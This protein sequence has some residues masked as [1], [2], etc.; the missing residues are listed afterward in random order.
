MEGRLRIILLES[1]LELVPRELQE[2]PEVIK[3]AKRYGISPSEVILDKSLHYNAMYKLSRKWK[4]GRPDIVH[5]TLLVIEGSYAGRKG[6]IEVF[7]HTI[8]GE[9]YAVRPGTRIPKH[10]ERFKGL[11]AQL[12]REG[13]V[14]P[15][16][17]E[18]LIYKVSNTLGEFVQRYGKIILMWEGGRDAREEEVVVRALALNA[19]VGIGMFPR[20]DFEKSTLR[21]AIGSY[22]LFG[23]EPLPAW[24]IASRIVMAF[25][26]ITLR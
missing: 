15:D 13:K 25:E 6:L 2:D 7:I 10:Y 4:R 12:L 22:R 21:K 9:V 8:K 26:N 3:T 24:T 18:P 17:K 14:P 1:G 11:M 20:G 19:P 5:T 23:G 16:S